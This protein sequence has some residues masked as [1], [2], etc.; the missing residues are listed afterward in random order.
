MTTKGQKAASSLQRKS[1]GKLSKIN[2]LY[3]S[4]AAKANH[5]ICFPRNCSKFVSTAILKG[6]QGNHFNYEGR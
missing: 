1:I 4:D 2:T 5:P 6:L 3:C